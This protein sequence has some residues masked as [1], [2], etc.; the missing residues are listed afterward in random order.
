MA[1]LILI[2]LE[3]IVLVFVTS[4]RAR[5]ACISIQS[6]QDFITNFNQL[7]LFTCEQ[8]HIVHKAVL[9]MTNIIIEYLYTSIVYQY[10]LLLYTCIVYQYCLLVLYTCIVYQYCLLVLYTSIA[11]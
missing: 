7:N 1:I 2:L 11:Y 3:P 4:I 8:I 5:L 9:K 10:C 6:D